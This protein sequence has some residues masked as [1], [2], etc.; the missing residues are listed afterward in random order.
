MRKIGEK[1]LSTYARLCGP[2]FLSLSPRL[3][4]KIYIHFI[5]LLVE[6]LFCEGPLVG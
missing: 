4:V 5:D 3:A 2:I 6:F 1:G